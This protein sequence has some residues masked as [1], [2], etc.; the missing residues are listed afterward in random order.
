MFGA[1]YDFC[2]DQGSIIAGLLAL[3]A[4]YI[5]FRGA[6]RAA[7]QQV[8]AVNAQ[9]EAVRQQNRD[10]RNE[11][12]RRLAQNGIVAVKLLDG[13]LEI[14]RT[15]VDELKRLLNQTQYF[16]TNRQAPPNYRQMIYKPPLSIVWDDLGAC[17]TLV[18]SNYILLDAKIS[19][20]A[21]TQ[22]H[23]VDVIQNELQI[24]INILDALGRELESDAA[25]HN[26]VLR[27]QD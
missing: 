5:A 2:R 14:I 7:Q 15:D 25:R 19:Q 24:I 3:V 11:G 20:F 27:Q 13:V 17:G 8:A 1:L 16:G 22:I 23:S 4:G 10:L 9:T 6:T 12:R 21:R 26:A 18:I